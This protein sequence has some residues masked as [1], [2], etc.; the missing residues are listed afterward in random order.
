M[1][2]F[3]GRAGKRVKTYQY[4]A[5]G[6]DELGSVQNSA[7]IHS[8]KGNVRLFFRGGRKPGRRKLSIDLNDESV[9]NYLFK[10]QTDFKR[11]PDPL[12]GLDSQD[13]IDPSQYPSRLSSCWN[14]D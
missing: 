2:Y 13:K 14:I 3:D 1:P 5:A 11:L 4:C 6:I 7:T 10:G 12:P 8:F 9:R